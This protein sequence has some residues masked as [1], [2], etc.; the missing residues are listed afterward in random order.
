MAVRS[1]IAGD[2][3]LKAGE[4]VAADVCLC[5]GASLVLLV[6]MVGV[7]ALLYGSSGLKPWRFLRQRLSYPGLFILAV[8][9]L[10]PLTAGR[11]GDLAVGLAIPQAGGN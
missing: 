5:N 3:P 10:L 4:F 7:T 1:F 6:P 8:V 2:R 11:H 9:I